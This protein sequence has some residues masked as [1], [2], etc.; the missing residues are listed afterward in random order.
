VKKTPVI[1]DCDPGNDDA[2]ALV[3]AFSAA[4]FDIKAVTVCAGNAGLEDVFQN[5]RKILGLLGQ[6]V[7]LAAGASKPMFRELVVAANIHGQRGLYAPTLGETDYP[8]EP[9]SAVA[10][11]RRIIT[12]SPAPVTIIATGPLTNLGFLFR[13][14]PEIKKNIGLI[15]FMGG[16]LIGG[17]T[18]AA[19]EFNF[20]VDPEAA[21]IVLS[22]GLPLIM[23][24]LNVT[25]KALIMKDEIET[26]R[27]VGGPVSVFTADLLD[28][29]LGV[30]LK[31]GYKG[32]A[33]H[34]P[35]AVACLVRPDLFAS[36]PCHVVVETRGT[37]TAGMSLADTRPYSKAKPNVTVNTEVNR[38]G[39]IYL[40][41][42]A[43]GTYRKASVYSIDL[44]N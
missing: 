36:R 11:M 13:D 6:R 7:P 44:F 25:R 16:S 18:T 35:C 8:T 37:H 40:L 2:V 42:D 23:S 15:S 43:V 33:L 10:L 14:F 5:A 9:V 21:D 12:E 24:G 38:E 39:L 1:I 34:D 28:Y 17:N 20:Y 22:S 41:M 3:L 30:Y 31:L 29:Y 4:E 27:A 19:A 26:L 32:A